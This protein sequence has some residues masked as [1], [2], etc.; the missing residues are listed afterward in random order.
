MNRERIADLL[1]RES[2]GG[3]A[4]ARGW[5]RSVRHSKGV[6]FLDMTDGSCLAGIQVVVGPELSNYETTVRSLGTGCAVR[7]TG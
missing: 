7:V 4:T 6:S 1:G 5:L 3:T 2:A